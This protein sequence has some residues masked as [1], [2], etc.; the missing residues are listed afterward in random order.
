MYNVC[1]LWAYNYVHEMYRVVFR[2][3]LR[4]VILKQNILYKNKV[5]IVWINYDKNTL[6]LNNLNIITGYMLM[7]LYTS[8]YIFHVSF[9]Y[10]IPKS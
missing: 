9:V 6:I 8:F 7:S 5:N 10:Y 4:T 2:L 1:M 3:K